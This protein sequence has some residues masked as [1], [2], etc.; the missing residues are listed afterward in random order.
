[1]FFE[2]IQQAEG[3]V[4]YDYA[5]DWKWTRKGPAQ[6]SFA[7]DRSQQNVD[8]DLLRKEITK[9]MNVYSKSGGWFRL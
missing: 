1:M 5:V 9:I 6:Y 2:R 4:R 7:A 8:A 3:S